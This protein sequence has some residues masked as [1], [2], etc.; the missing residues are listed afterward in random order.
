MLSVGDCVLVL[1][2]FMLL[3]QLIAMTYTIIWMI[4]DSVYLSKETPHYPTEKFTECNCN[5]FLVA[6]RTK[7]TLC[8]YQ[9]LRDLDSWRITVLVLGVRAN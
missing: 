2:I 7:R 8:P 9:N 5:Y 4:S 3:M 6:M 1:G